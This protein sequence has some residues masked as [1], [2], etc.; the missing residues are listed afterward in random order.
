M[1]SLLKTYKAGPIDENYFRNYGGQEYSVN[2]SN[3]TIPADRI[4]KDLVDNNVDFRTILDIGC[5]SGELVRDF[6]NLGVEAF[7]IE[8]NKYILKNNLMPEYCTQMDMRDISKFK[9]GAF[10][11]G[12][13]NSLMYLFPQE[14]PKVLKKFSNVFNKGIYICMPFLEEPFFPDPYR[15]FLASEKWWERQFEDAGFKKKNS[16]IYI[17]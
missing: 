14:V 6:R 16:D 7:G 12:Y 4:V 3:F 9:N 10:D 1:P 15:K 2:Y 5:A 17:K 11:V 13:A 8:N